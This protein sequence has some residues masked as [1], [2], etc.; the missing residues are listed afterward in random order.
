MWKTY[1]FEPSENHHLQVVDF[2]MLVYPRR[3]NGIY[4][5]RKLLVGGFNPS[6]VGMSIPNIWEKMFQS[7]NQIGMFMGFSRIDH[8]IL[9][10]QWMTWMLGEGMFQT[11]GLNMASQ[12]KNGAG[13]CQWTCL[14]GSLEQW[15]CLQSSSANSTTSS[16]QMTSTRHIGRRLAEI[17]R[18]ITARLV[19]ALGGGIRSSH[20]SHPVGT[21]FRLSKFNGVERLTTDWIILDQIDDMR[22]FNSD[23]DSRGMAS[24]PSLP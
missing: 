4:C 23:H 24:L 8:Q 19:A 11:W 10:D 7:T 5:R 3:I 13:W 6:S 18:V 21:E 1:G 22:E 17:R 16:S 2:P 14:M 12:P 15:C 9:K 20:P